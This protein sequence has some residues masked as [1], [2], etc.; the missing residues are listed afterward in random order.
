MDYTSD[1]GFQETIIVTQIHILNN[2]PV[3]DHSRRE[4]ATKII[5]VK[6]HGAI[7]SSVKRINKQKQSIFTTDKT[8]EMIIYICTVPF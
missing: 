6:S 8:K 5:K 2:P 1:S 4:F 7:S 3:S